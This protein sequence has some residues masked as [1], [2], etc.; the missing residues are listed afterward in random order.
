MFSISNISI[1]PTIDTTNADGTLKFSASLSL[2]NN[3]VIKITIAPA[4]DIF[5]AG[6]MISAPHIAKVVI[7]VPNVRTED[8]PFQQQVS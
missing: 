1:K 6:V 5:P 2:A 7:G 3:N 4:K 8:I